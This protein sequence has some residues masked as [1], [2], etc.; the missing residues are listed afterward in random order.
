M[1][2][3]DC[4]IRLFPLFREEGFHAEEKQKEDR[5]LKKGGETPSWPSV[6]EAE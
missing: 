1:D 5:R 4:K 3:R 6:D 2:L